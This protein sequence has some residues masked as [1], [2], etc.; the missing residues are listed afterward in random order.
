MDVVA[1]FITPGFIFLLT[2]VSGFWLSN[3]GKPLNTVIFTVHKLIALAAVIFTSIAIYSLI[4]NV[5]IQSLIVTLIVIVVV[6]ILVSFLTGA[7]LSLD[8]PK[9]NILLIIHKTAPLLAVISLAVTIY[10]VGGRKL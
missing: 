4:K 3:S 5:E 9:N 2:L 1:K 6:C 10:L 7:L 8:I